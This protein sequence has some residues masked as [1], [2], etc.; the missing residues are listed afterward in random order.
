MSEKP[1]FSLKK[2]RRIYSDNDED[3]EDE[4]V[5]DGLD[6]Y[7]HYTLLA[8]G[9]EVSKRTLS[10]ILNLDGKLQNVKLFGP[11][12]KIPRCHQEMYFPHQI[13]CAK[14]DSKLRPAD[15]LQLC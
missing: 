15:K 12:W 8:G 4:D 13:K 7:C 10:R 14:F 3:D 11:G 5:E 1:A 6:D 9:E 2:A